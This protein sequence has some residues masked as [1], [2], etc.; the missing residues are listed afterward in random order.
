M[1]NSPS[2]SNCLYPLTIV[3]NTLSS[4]W[5]IIERLRRECPWDRKQTLYSLRFSLIEEAYELYDALRKRNYKKTEEELGDLLFLTLFLMLIGEEEKRWKIQNLIKKVSD[6]LVYRHPH[7]FKKKRVEN[8]EDVLINWEK[9][10]RKSSNS[11]LSGIPKSLPALRKAQLIQT[12]VRRVKF[13]WQD[14]RGPLEKMEEEMK[15]LKREI[16]KGNKARMEEELGDLL[17]SITNLSRHLGLDAEETLNKSCEKFTHRFKKI[18]KRLS[19][20]GKTPSGSSLEE[21]DRIWEEL[22]RS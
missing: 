9:L 4:L 20:L 6:K 5:R 10:K 12:R 15:E 16:E 2:H 19:E 11:I 22:K 8:I 21:M 13:D 7:V 17:F 3:K 14:Y 1:G 18:E